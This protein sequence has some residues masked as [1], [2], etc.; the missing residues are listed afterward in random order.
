MSRRDDAG[1]P[2]FV[3]QLIDYILGFCLLFS[4]M[5]FPHLAAVVAWVAGG[6]LILLAMLSDTAIGLGKVE[7]RTHATIDGIVVAVL[8]ASPILFH[9]TR[10]RGAFVTLEAAGVLLLWLTARTAYI[11]PARRPIAGTARDVASVMP[12]ALGRAIGKATRDRG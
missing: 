10:A 9:F 7:R 1:F 5:R 11:K 6:M 12:R 2:F 8:V 3:H 4:G